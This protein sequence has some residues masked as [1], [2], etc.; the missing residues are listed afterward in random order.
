[1]ALSLL[2][3]QRFNEACVSGPM[4]PKYGL[5]SLYNQKCGLQDLNTQKGRNTD[6][7]TDIKIKPEGNK[8]MSYDIR[9][10]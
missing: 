10:L 7:R 3:N 9:Y 8:I 2:K 6:G 4:K 5:L 1:M